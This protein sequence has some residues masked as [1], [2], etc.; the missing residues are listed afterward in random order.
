MLAVAK[1]RAVDHF[2]Q[3]QTQQRRLTDL[4]HRLKENDMPGLDA[5]VDYIRMT[6][7]G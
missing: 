3:S 7:C 6:C 2:R 1:R 4:G 5:Q